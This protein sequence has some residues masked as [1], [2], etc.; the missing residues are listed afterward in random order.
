MADKR[1]RLDGGD[2]VPEGLD[3]DSLPLPPWPEI[4]GE[5]EGEELPPSPAPAPPPVSGSK[6][7]PQW[8]PLP[9]ISGKMEPLPETAR[10]AGDALPMPEF[11]KIASLPRSKVDP[12]WAPLPDAAQA[13][14]QWMP[15]PDAAQ[16]DPQWAPLPDFVGGMDPLPDATSSAGSGPP[17]PSWPIVGPATSPRSGDGMD[18]LPE[19]K[20]AVMD[21]L[22]M[23]EFP[24]IASPSRGGLEHFGESQSF[25]VAGGGVQPMG[26]AV[27]AKDV[28]Q[29]LGKIEQMMRDLVREVLA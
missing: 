15:L 18:P 7:D 28:P 22:P 16:V 5:A 21:A 20:P 19:A 27:S 11:P 24:A 26:D 12:Q 4:A 17:L 10:A 9:E 8:T 25:A 29:I 2:E 6:A 14:P 3:V 23:P 13:D 1:H